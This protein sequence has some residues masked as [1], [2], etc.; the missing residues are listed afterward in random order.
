MSNLKGSPSIFSKAD[1]TLGAAAT[2]K[3]T[4]TVKRILSLHISGSLSNL[5]LAGPQAAMWKPLSGKESDVLK[6]Y[7]GAAIDSSEAMNRLRGGAVKKLTVMEHSSTFPVPIG[8][9][10]NCIS[11]WE[12]T[13]MGENYAYTVLPKSSL[14]SPQTVFEADASAH[15]NASW[16]QLYPQYNSANLETEGVMDAPNQPWAFVHKHHPVIGLLMNNQEMIGVQ[17]EKQP[18]VEGEWYKLARNVMST[19]CQTLR[20][21]V[22]PKIVNQ[23]LN[24]LTIQAHR[25]D[26]DSW[27]DLGDGT[28]ALQGFT[29]KHDWTEEEVKAAK[30]HHLHQFLETPCHY[31]A[32]LM[33]EYEVPATP[34]PS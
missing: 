11:P 10:M 31:F 16:K 4:L 30:A 15:E 9:S 13:D 8:I 32:R 33:L 6:P 27:D 19:C 2:D 21:Q 29:T 14:S 28:L 20:S 34:T 25:I 5:N 24:T 3:K 17:L 7:L 18:L 22:L 26:A 23:D 1:P 12:A